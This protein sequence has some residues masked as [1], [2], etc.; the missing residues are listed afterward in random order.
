MR[1]FLR[2]ARG[3]A[4]NDR[5][6]AQRKNITSR[7]S[8]AEPW[9]ICLDARTVFSIREDCM[10]FSKDWSERW[11]RFLAPP[12]SGDRKALD[13]LRQRYVEEMQAAGRFKQHAQEMQ[14]P[15]F[16]EKLL[17]IATEKSKHAE[18]IAEKIATLAGKL[19]E[20]PERRS[21]DENSWQYLLTDLEEENRSVDHLPEQIWS[22]E[23]DHPDITAVLQ[24]I[25]EEEKKYR[26][27]IREMLMRS[28]SFALSLA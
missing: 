21:M 14:Y 15:Q 3:N 12:P 22:I 10:A 23:S 4:E 19:P 6:E 13:I 17:H 28:D 18:W 7:H 9:L 16:R 1:Y 27:E 8:V 5:A 20:V 26:G 25:Y 2:S 24:R 11:R